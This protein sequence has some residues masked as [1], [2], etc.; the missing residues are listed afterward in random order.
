MT[1]L[2]SALGRGSLSSPRPRK[3]PSIS[4]VPRLC[5]PRQVFME[6]LLRG[7]IISQWF[8]TFPESQH[9][10]KK[11]PLPRKCCWE[12][13]RKQR[14]SGHDRAPKSQ[15]LSTC[16]RHTMPGIMMLLIF[17]R[18]PKVTW[19]GMIQMY[20]QQAPVLPLSQWMAVPSIHPSCCSGWNLRVTLNTPSPLVSFTSSLSL[21]SGPVFRQNLS[22]PPPLFKLPS[23]RQ[24]DLLAPDW[25]YN[26]RSQHS[27]R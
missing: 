15:S 23:F 2:G 1:A 16:E 11:A 12:I 8:L 5:G 7:N 25:V 3:F 26:R 27:V 21:N 19:S 22:H 24:G 9:S 20:K 13:N 18:K 4:V 17:G 6:W 10:L 14:C